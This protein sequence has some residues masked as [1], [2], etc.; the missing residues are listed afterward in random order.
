MCEMSGLSHE[1]LLGRRVTDIVD[2]AERETVQRHWQARRAGGSDP[3]EIGWRRPDGGFRHALIS[4]CPRFD[5]AGN[6]IG[7]IAVVTD[8]T[9]RKK[10]EDDLKE[11]HDH[12][13]LLRREITH[14]VGNNLATLMGLV[15]ASSAHASSVNE[16]AEALSRRIAAMQRV[17]AVLARAEWKGGHVTDVVQGALAA[18]AQE[19][20]DCE[21]PE[22]NLTPRESTALGLVL[23]ELAT[24]AAK[25]GA[26]RGSAGR[27][28][29]RWEQLNG[30]GGDRLA[31]HWCERDGDPIDPPDREGLGTQLVRGLVE[32]DLRGQVELSYPS[33]G[34]AH[35]FTITLDER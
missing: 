5:E 19:S 1:E 18:Y 24:N 12:E 31:F 27:V 4:P 13:L 16:F 33:E 26:L 28:E 10:A 7:S 11:R 22:A 8:I 14:R 6:F 25:Y 30:T 29:L 9:N 3:Y 35:R 23:N 20:I 34:A 15:Q 32:S 21:G 2:P 17:H